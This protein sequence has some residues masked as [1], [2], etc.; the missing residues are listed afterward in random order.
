VFN[1]DLKDL[2]MLSTELKRGLGAEMVVMSSK[3]R[4]VQE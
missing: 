2:C 4:C 3:N 1:R